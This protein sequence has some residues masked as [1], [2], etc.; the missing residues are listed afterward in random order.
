MARLHPSRSPW[1][2]MSAVLYAIT[3]RDLRARFIQNVN[4]PRSLAFVWVFLEPM[5]HVAI[6]SAIRM[7]YGSHIDYGMPLLLFI[8][9][10]A[11]PWLYFKQ[12]FGGN[13]TAFKKNSGLYLH[14]QIKP[15]DP[16]IATALLELGIQICVFVVVL[17][18]FWWF[19][20]SLSIS[21]PLRWLFC[22]LTY[23]VFVLGLG[24]LFAV[25]GF[26][27]PFFKNLMRIL[28]RGLYLISGVFFAASNIPY[29]MRPYFTA[30]PVFQII[31][32]SR[33][34]FMPVQSHF[35]LTSP[36][37]LAESALVSLF[38]GLTVYFWARR[39]ILTEYSQR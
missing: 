2:V 33:E 16:I 8:F 12:V 7:M 10:G 20:M 17:T 1:R 6:W 26:F 11:M 18:G 31:E 39:R 38:V 36:E 13:L 9:L 4:T 21:H 23:A 28:M 37:Y 24:L 30:N 34:S 22:Y 35:T 14:R 5:M 25:I 27:F 19:G 3:V 29:V 32:I 15:I